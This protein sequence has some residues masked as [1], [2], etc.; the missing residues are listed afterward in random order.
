MRP[1][2]SRS[3]AGL[4]YHRLI[5]PARLP[6]RGRSENRRRRSPVQPFI[7]RSRAPG[8][9]RSCRLWARWSGKSR[10]RSHWIPEL[11]IIFRRLSQVRGRA[12]SVVRL[13]GL[14]PITLWLVSDKTLGALWLQRSTLE[15]PF[16]PDDLDVWHRLRPGSI[17]RQLSR[18]KERFSV[19]TAARGACYATCC[20]RRRYGARGSEQVAAN[21]RRC[22]RLPQAIALRCPTSWSIAGPGYDPLIREVFPLAPGSPSTWRRALNL[23]SRAGAI[24]C[25]PALA[26][27][28]GQWAPICCS[29]SLAA[30]GAPWLAQ[31]EAARALRRTARNSDSGSTMTSESIVA[32]QFTARKEARRPRITS[33]RGR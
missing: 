4:G 13:R 5:V 6:G 14:L 32:A 30:G 10:G 21:R 2:T 28:R 33:A 17:G 19:H 15:M 18:S 23:A 29:F 31:L 3:A 12:R 11:W 9:F 25:Y 22:A 24:C 16:G 27:I 26:V 1:E 7:G 20:W 8:P